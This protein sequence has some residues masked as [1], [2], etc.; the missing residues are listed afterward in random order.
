MKLYITTEYISTL[1]ISFLFQNCRDNTMGDH[2]D[3]CFPGHYGDPAIEPCQICSCPLPV[4][5]NK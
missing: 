3:Q 1:Y 5:S 2:C 4:A